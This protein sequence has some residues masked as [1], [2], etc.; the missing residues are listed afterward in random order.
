MNVS[1]AVLEKWE[2]RLDLVER[3]VSSALRVVQALEARVQNCEA[4]L[5]HVTLILARPFWGRLK[6]LLLGK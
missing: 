6:W 4:G 1:N 5:A 2:A 3:Q